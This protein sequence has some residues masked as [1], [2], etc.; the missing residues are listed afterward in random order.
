MMAG[1]LLDDFSSPSLS[2]L[3]EIVRPRV[4]EVRKEVLESPVPFL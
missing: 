1:A 2:P 4:V 3:V